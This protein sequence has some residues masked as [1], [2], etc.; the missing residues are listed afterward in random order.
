M[1][2]HIA[3][4]IASGDIDPLTKIPIQVLFSLSLFL[5]ISSPFIIIAIIN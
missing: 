4:G 1:P 5:Y 3:K 2:Q